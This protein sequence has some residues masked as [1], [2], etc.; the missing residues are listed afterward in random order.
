MTFS[1]SAG[2]QF[3]KNEMLKAAEGGVLKCLNADRPI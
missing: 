2:Q 3:S 1:I